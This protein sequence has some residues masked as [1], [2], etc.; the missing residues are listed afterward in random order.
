MDGSTNGKSPLRS[1]T[2]NKLVISKK[3]FAYLIFL[4]STSLLCL[5]SFQEVNINNIKIY[6]TD[7]INQE[8][9]L[10]NSTLLLPKELIHIKTKKHEVELKENLSLKNISI[11]RQLFP[12][13][14]KIFIQLRDPIAYAEKN[15]NKK[16][17]SGFIDEEGF[18]IKKEFALLKKD[19]PYAL[20]VMGW[21]KISQ[22]TISKIISAYKKNKDLKRIYISSDDGYIIIEEEKLKKIYLGNQPE[23][24][25]LQLK[26]IF[27]IREQVKDEKIFRKI[28]NLDITDIKNPTL[29]VF[30]R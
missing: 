25:D 26:L 24:I 9:I 8:I 4:L 10:K 2:E 7:F 11:R 23:Q 20:K 19:L 21:R 15:D 22:E 16:I 27:E 14:L 13:G 6:G 3:Y 29:K 30:K 17:I 12:F 28:E 1:V 18:F 5:K